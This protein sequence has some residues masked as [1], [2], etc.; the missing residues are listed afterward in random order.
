M[1]CSAV[2]RDL[3]IFQISSRKGNVRNDFN[4]AIASLGDTDLI[5]E[6]ARASFDFDLVVEEFL[7]GR[8]VEDLI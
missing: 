1:Q 3:Q 6:V 2:Q 8:Q 7:E 5:A 4:F